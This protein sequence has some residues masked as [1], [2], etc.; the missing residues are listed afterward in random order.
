MIT[1]TVPGNPIPKQ[2]F[3]YAKGGGYQ[4]QRVKDWQ[5]LVAQ[6]AAIAMMGQDLYQWEVEVSI[7]FRRE[8]QR[9]VDLDNLSKS[10]LDSC[11]GI[12]WNDDKQVMKLHLE[13]KYDKHNPGIEVEVHEIR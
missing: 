4:P 5:D 8:N 10:V 2:S 13:K 6:Y 12:V 9:K 11:N 1:F 3:R 7:E